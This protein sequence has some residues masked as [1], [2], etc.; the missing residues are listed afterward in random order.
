MILAVKPRQRGSGTVLAM[1][2]LVVVLAALGGLVFWAGSDAAQRGEEGALAPLAFGLPIATPAA[3]AL[4]G[5]SER[6]WLLIAAGLSLLPMTILSFSYLFVLLFLPAC[7]FFVVAIT[8]PR[9]PVHARAQPLAALLCVGFVLAA[10]V[11]LLGGGEE[12]TVTTGTATWSGQVMPA[13]SAL[14]T[15]A[16]VV[17]ALTIAWLAPKDR[18]ARDA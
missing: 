15:I 10:V 14:T 17:A 18:A 8:R 7:T 11:N 12:R 3:L 9:L 5:W 13:R 1:A 16:F 6:P 2:G 4:L